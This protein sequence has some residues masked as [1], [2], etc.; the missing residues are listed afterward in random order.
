MVV[1]GYGSHAESL[2]GLLRSGPL[3]VSVVTLDPT[4]AA[5]LDAGAEGSL[6]PAGGGRLSVHR[7]SNRR[8]DALIAAGVADADAVV[9]ADDAPEDAAAIAHTL[10]ADLRVSPHACFTLGPGE[11][12]HPDLE[13]LRRALAAWLTERRHTPDA[14]AYAIDGGSPCTH[15][16]ALRLPPLPVAAR[17]GLACPACVAAGEP[18]VHLRRCA[19]CGRVGCCDSSPNRHARAHADAC[20]HP[21]IEPLS[22]GEGRWVYCYADDAEAV[23]ERAAPPPAILR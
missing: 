11:G 14:S 10:H 12:M 9:V 16:G 8:T 3:D 2:L 19:T 6:R 21:L 22:E 18:W 1:A 23:A 20:G 5:A 4:R 7:G 15:A 13:A 17:E